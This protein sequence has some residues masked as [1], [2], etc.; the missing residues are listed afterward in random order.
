MTLAWH[1]TAENLC[2]GRPLPADGETLRHDGPLIMCESGLHASERLLDALQY[3]PGPIVWR[4]ECAVD[5]KRDTDKLICRERTALWHLDATD[6]LR[7]FTRKCALD[8]AHLWEMPSIVR[9]YL[10]TGDET[11]RAAAEAVAWAA[12]EV[13]A[14][15]T[16]RAAATAARAAWA[17]EAAWIIWVAGVAAR[18]TRIAGAA[19]A[20][21]WDTQDKHLTAMIE[22]AHGR[23][24]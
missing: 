12:A 9:Q 16:A 3:A 1:F 15:V 6:L 13:T 22:Q 10:E 24:K 2:D 4:V 11:I 17:A 5:I 18:A 19:G 20:A 7:E 14:G 21:A 23:M 8:V